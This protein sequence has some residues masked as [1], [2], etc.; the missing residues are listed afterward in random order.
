MDKASMDHVG[1]LIAT[2]AAVSLFAFACAVCMRQTITQPLPVFTR[3]LVIYTGIVLLFFSIGCLAGVGLH[4][5]DAY[6]STHQAPWP[7]ASIFSEIGMV[8]FLICLP[9]AWIY[10]MIN[11]A[12]APPD[13]S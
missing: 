13:W 12:K 9:V 8:M 5:R 1:H 4:R 6:W 2:F 7:G 3:I 11:K 10:N